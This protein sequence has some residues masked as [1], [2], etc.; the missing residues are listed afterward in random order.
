MS[1]GFAEKNRFNFDRETPESSIRGPGSGESHGIR[2]EDNQSEE[3][4]LPFNYFE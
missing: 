3:F 4:T 2:W 1:R